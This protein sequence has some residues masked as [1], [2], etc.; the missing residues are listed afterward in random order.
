MGPQVVRVLV[1]DLLDEAEEI[2]TSG[3]KNEFFLPE[4]EKGNLE[5][6]IMTDLSGEKELKQ[7][8]LRIAQLEQIESRFRSSEAMEYVVKF[9]SVVL[10]ILSA[11][12][13]IWINDELKNTIGIFATFI[14]GFIIL[15]SSVL[16]MVI[17]KAFTLKFS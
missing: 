3:E 14:A 5:K 12:F 7:L 2:H 1:E 4:S 15:S 6:T 16:S 10:F 11:M 9:V 13:A 8:M 17:P